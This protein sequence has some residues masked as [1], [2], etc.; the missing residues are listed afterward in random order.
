MRKI[1]FVK[2]AELYL[3]GNN[4]P[5]FI[6]ALYKNIKKGLVGIQS[7]VIK[8]FDCIKVEDFSNEEKVINILSRIPGIGQLRITYETNTNIDDICKTIEQFTLKEGTFKV[9]TKRKFKDFMDSFEIKTTIASYLLKKYDN[10]KV[11]VKNPD[12]VINVEINKNNSYIYVEK[13]KALGGFPV[14]TG[15]KVL[16][17]ISGGIDSPV[18]SHLLQK[19]GFEVDY[20][21]FITSEVT[22]KT[23]VKI[24]NLINKIT[25]NGRIYKPKFYIVDFTSVQNELAHISDERYRITLMRRSFYRIANKV[26]NE[27]NY[28]ALVCGDSLGQVASQTIESI[29]CIND[30]SQVSIFRPLLTYDKEEIIKISK[31][32]KTYD[33]SI[34]EHEDICS[35]FA[36]KKPITK[37]TIKK[38]IE[39]ES[40]LFLLDAL[41]EKAFIN[42]KLVENK[43]E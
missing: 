24:V 2:F 30:S 5:T 14:G 43:G 13:I 21:T 15:G 6:N 18:A 42:K 4:K 32:I 37:P 34:V 28:Q 26:C 7:N 12:F 11:D 25:L 33:I 40:E 36:P 8:Q 23:L 16:S 29:N 9:E 10:I 20:I 17:L 31:N 27:K 41:E 39:L 35:A 19:K 38:A 1:I 22:T 3:K